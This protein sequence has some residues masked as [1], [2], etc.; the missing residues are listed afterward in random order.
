M[1]PAWHGPYGQKIG[2]ASRVP[3]LQYYRL[4]HDSGMLVGIRCDVSL[5]AVE[6]LVYGLTNSR[7]PEMWFSP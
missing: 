3:L 5:R 4:R 7:S 1:G 6:V 2:A